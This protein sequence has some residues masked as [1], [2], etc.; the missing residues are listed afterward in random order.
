MTILNKSQR[1]NLSNQWINQTTEIRM[2]EKEDL[3]GK[4]KGNFR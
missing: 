4:G 3:V 1:E 2:K